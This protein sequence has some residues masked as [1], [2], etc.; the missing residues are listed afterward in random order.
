MNENE[1]VELN[2]DQLG[3]VAG[4]RALNSE[5]SNAMKEFLERLYDRRRMGT[6]TDEEFYIGNRIAMEYKRLISSLSEE[7]ASDTY[8]I[9]Q[10][11]KA[12][13]YTKYL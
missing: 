1:N 7:S 10:Y 2:V 9:D 8:T 13:R 11:L 6:L 12:K 5:E 3:E 4:G